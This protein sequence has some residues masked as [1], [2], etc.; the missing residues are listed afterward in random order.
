MPLLRDYVFKG[1]LWVWRSGMSL[2]RASS[3]DGAAGVTGH[4]IG[5]ICQRHMYVAVRAFESVIREACSFT[6]IAVLQS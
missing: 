5:V 3:F 6:I 1:Y 2:A 4:M